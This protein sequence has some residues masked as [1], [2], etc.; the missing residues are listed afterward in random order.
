M[1][2][3][4][5]AYKKFVA[6][7]ATATLVASALAPVASAAAS[8]SFKD[9]S[10][11]YKESVN[12][13]VDNG[14]AKGTSDTTFGTTS[15]ISRGDA[16]VMIANALKLDTANA[17]DAGFQDLNSRVEGAV[18]A[19]VEAKIA[20]GK[21]ATKFDPA[22]YITRQEMAK[23]LANA[24]DLKSTSKADFKD[25]NANWIDYVSALK[26]A[27]ITLGTSET[28]FSPTNNLTRGEF[29]LFVFRAENPD[30]DL[31]IVDAVSVVNETTTTAKL[32]V[33]NK[34]LTAAD[35]KVL[36]NG[37]A[38]T[39]TSV[40]S[41]AKGEVYTITH[42][43]LKDTKGVVSVNG[44][45]ADFN[46]VVVEAKV[47]SVKAINGTQVEVKFTQAVDKA[48]AQ[49]LGKVTIEGVTLTN[50][51]LS[52][53]GKTLTLT[54]AMTSGSTAVD[55]KNAA[56]VV[57]PIKTKADANVMTDKF[58]SL[59]TFKDEVA[60]TIASVE[61]KS[62]GTKATELT[63]KTSEPIQSAVAKVNGEYVSV[64]FAGT[65]SAT[66]TGLSLETGKTHTLELINLEDKAGNK[67]VTTSASF[68]VSVDSVAPVSTLTQ[69]EDSQILVT[70]NKEMN[71]SSV[72][73]ALANGAVKDEAL[74]AI[75]TGTV[76]E[77]ADSNGT[78]FIIPVSTGLYTNDRTSR[79]LN[80]ALA[81][82]IKDSLG[83]KLVATSQKVTLTKDTTKPA[84]TGYNLVKDAD[85]KIKAVEVNFNKGLVA[86]AVA[87]GK[88][89]SHADV[90]TSIVNENGVI[91]GSTFDSFVAKA[92]SAGDT[93][94]VFEATPA[95]AVN[96]KYAFS[97][98]NELVQDQ[99]QGANKSN[100]FNYTVDFGQGKTNTEFE[101]PTAS[102]PTANSNNEITV[103]FPEAVK[104]G[105]VAGSATDISNYTLAG[106]PL[107]TGTTITLNA[108][109][110]PA[111]QTVATIKMP[112]DSV[113]KDDANAVFTAANIKNT[114]G[115]KTLKSYSGTLAVKDNTKPVLQSA[116]VLDNKTIELTYSEAM[117]TGL[118]NTEVKN[119]FII[120][121]GSTTAIDFTSA[122]SLEANNVSGFAN[123]VRITINKNETAANAGSTEI[124]GTNAGIASKTSGTTNASSTKNY[125]VANKVTAPVLTGA[126][127]AKVS[128]TSG[129]A[130]AASTVQYN[131]VDNAGTLE[132][133]KQ[134]DSSVVIADLATTKTFVQDGVTFTVANSAADTDTFTVA[135]TKT[136]L[137][138]QDAS[139]DS[140]VI[141]DLSAGQTFTQDGVT[142]TVAPSAAAGNTF[143]VKTV[144]AGAT[145]KVTL[146]LD[147]DITVETKDSSVITD[148]ST[149]KNH[150]KAE[151]KVTVAK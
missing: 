26:E 133:Q 95:K 141:A 134:S 144:D 86:G 150:Q 59:L 130:T 60:P 142:F 63:V 106:K 36:V 79:T 65:N 92:V 8:D 121:N 55:V 62:N 145:S 12:Y 58:I 13:L 20:S 85:G 132:L 23:M 24:Y 57:N 5:N 9:V 87:T 110:S 29:A 31:A 112:A 19:I 118:S 50:P 96:G 18:N 1:A 33:A 71:V 100:A 137:Q 94:V 81:D 91:E 138:L 70:F 105:A 101:L 90:T 52:A 88:A 109:P 151:V 64:N 102:L 41:D 51:S 69:K 93:K 34:D 139:D 4:P 146:D 28:T 114:A 147:K 123:K 7:A 126:Q 125:K 124:S 115:T 89:L 67:T 42:A 47:E 131:V 43:S 30:A 66:I 40:V 107:P 104:G 73:T 21:T 2:K 82:T 120:M 119:D 76:T 80:V 54:A 15:N 74:G 128:A 98:K 45:Q 46:F 75:T 143:T 103:T 44:K 53:D 56:V 84:A 11:N 111:A 6:T 48:D 140:A 97:F 148:N 127:S 116:K 117:V 38:V 77:V 22:A 72:T 37:T 3:Q 83:N 25:V 17:K 68:S 39:P 136:L 32:K 78:Q 129:A 108:G 113:A 16:A 122:G 135:T 35:F 99:A 149:K 61:A 49:T 10:S 27:G 14:I